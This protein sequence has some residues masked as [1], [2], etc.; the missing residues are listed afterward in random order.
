[1]KTMG[2]IPR[3]FHK[4]IDSYI[5]E[6]FVG[7]TGGNKLYLKARLKQELHDGITIQFTD[8]FI[9]AALSII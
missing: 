6:L 7:K 3:Y 5:S 1:M 9:E 8:T 4:H 2:W